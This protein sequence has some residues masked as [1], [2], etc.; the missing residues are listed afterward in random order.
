MKQYKKS[1][2]VPAL[3]S[4]AI[5][6]ITAPADAG[7]T[8]APP[9]GPEMYED[10]KIH[11]GFRA[12]GKEVNR[13]DLSCKGGDWEF[14]WAGYVRSR[15]GD[16][17]ELANSFWEEDLSDPR[18]AVR[19][20][21]ITCK[22]K[23]GEI[24]FRTSSSFSNLTVDVDLKFMRG[25]EVL[26]PDGK[27]GSSRIYYGTFI[28]SA[29]DD[30][31][32][33]IVYSKGFPAQKE[34]NAFTVISEDAWVK[35]QAEGLDIAA[36]HIISPEPVLTIEEME[37]GFVKKYKVEEKEEYEGV[38]GSCYGGPLE[39][40]E[41]V[42]SYK[43]NPE[44]KVT[45]EGCTDLALGKKETI[46]AVAEPAGGKFRFWIEPPSTLSIQPS[47]GTAVLTGNTPGR[48]TVKVEYT[49]NGKSATDSKPGSAVELVSMNGGNPIPPLSLYDDNGKKTKPYE[50]PVEVKPAGGISLL[51]FDTD[52]PVVSIMPGSKSIV[53]QPAYP[54]RATLQ[55]KTSCGEP[56]GPALAIEVS[57]CDGKTAARRDELRN[58][59]KALQEAINLNL[60]AVQEYMNDPDFADLKIDRRIQTLA[61]KTSE[62]VVAT[63][64]LMPG[65]G[66][67]VNELN[68][69]VDVVNTIT[70]LETGKIGDGAVGAVL[71]AGDAAGDLVGAASKAASYVKTW[72]EAYDAAFKFGEE[73]GTLIGT[74]ENVAN[75]R[76]WIDKY[77]EDLK[78]VSEEFKKLEEICTR[79]K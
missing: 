62:V 32:S 43:A 35:G 71:I 10:D 34:P 6:A 70:D 11:I 23:E 24:V 19:Y 74:A 61:K 25:D 68:T 4:V 77:Y 41:L 7:K 75:A 47:G 12:K 50:F 2:S 3:C 21:P 46:T 5:M 31:D 45:L 18:P 55:A 52:K 51:S 69:T 44:P 76:K 37:K 73:L 28:F 15:H 53:I 64:A 59:I 39:S 33:C 49:V 54:G 66:K 60:K 30:I 26:G 36:R 78:K 72:N 38:T 14:S 27:W 57:A 17:D 13:Q 79:K 9:A 58:E 29:N 42:L 56:V 65:A 48:S 8:A 16:G 1:I 63:A 22:D 40:G 67:G 20:T